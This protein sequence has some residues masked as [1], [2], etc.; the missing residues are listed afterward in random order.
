MKTAQ[1]SQRSK[2]NNA[3]LVAWS[4]AVREGKGGESF[5]GLEACNLVTTAVKVVRD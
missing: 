4:R 5:R 2:A 3:V 1:K